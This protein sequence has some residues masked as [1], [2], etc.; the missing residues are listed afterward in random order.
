MQIHSALL[1]HTASPNSSRQQADNWVSD[2]REYRR[3]LDEWFVQWKQLLSTLPE[4]DGDARVLLSWGQ[5]N[6]YHGVYLISLVWPTPGGRPSQICEA[7][8]KAALHLVRHQHLY[9]RPGSAG[10]TLPVFFPMSWTSSHFALQLSLTSITQESLGA[11][12]EEDKRSVLSQCLPLILLLETD[13]DNLL[14][15]SSFLLEE[16]YDGQD[17]R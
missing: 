11:E 13:P 6:Y 8:S 1:R 2:C 5:F 17:Q 12:E 7:V 16:L 9:A 14:T 3:G 10:I 15:G 4:D